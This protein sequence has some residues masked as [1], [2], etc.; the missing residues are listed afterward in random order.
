RSNNSWQHNIPTLVKGRERC[1]LQMHPD[2]ARARGLTTGSTAT[3]T[4]AVGSIEAPV[5]VTDAVMAGVVSMPHGWGHDLD[6]TRLSVARRRPGANNNRHASN[7][8]VD[9]LSGN[10]FLNGV[11]VEVEAAP[12][13]PSATTRQ[14]V[15]NQED[16]E[17]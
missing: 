15:P 7:D 12:H 8:D 10:P 13:D 1:V 6:G 3:V 11:P 2:D 16:D 9:P 14:T 17:S 4:S 5:E